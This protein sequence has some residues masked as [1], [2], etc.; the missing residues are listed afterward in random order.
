MGRWLIQLC[1]AVAACAAAPE[2]AGVALPIRSV[3]LDGNSFAYVES[4]GG[5]PLIFVHGGFQDYRMWLPALGQFGTAFRAIT[6][7][8]RNH[9]PNAADTD[10]LPDFAADEH[11]ADLQRLVEAMNLGRVH[12]VAHSSG[13]HAA[14]FFAA[15]RPDMV[16]SLTIVEPPASA[17]LG[18]TPEDKAALAS[19]NDRFALALVAL[20]NRDDMAAARQFADAVGGPGTYERRSPAQRAMM[21]DNIAAHVADARAKRVRPRFTCDMAARITAPVLLINGTRSPAFFHR[22]ADRL[23]ACLPHDE[24]TEI[25]ASHTV[26][27][28]NPR[29]FYDAVRRFLDKQP[30]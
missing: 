4:G 2:P 24:R 9:F 21:I 6:Y 18:D 12:L 26:P 5:P 29:A 19:F 1:L 20:R 11:A 3:T 7:S 13:A 22:V 17:L 15:R 25:N 10:G 23:S 30:R 8:R 28:E 14:L 16:R 27:T